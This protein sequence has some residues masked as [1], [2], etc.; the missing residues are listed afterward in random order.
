MRIRVD[1]RAAAIDEERAHTC[2][3]IIEHT[4]HILHASFEPEAPRRE[5]F[6]L[7]LHFDEPG[8]LSVKILLDR[9]VSARHFEMFLQHQ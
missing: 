8:L 6:V 3:H 2:S 5:H 4:S 1:R 9:F 7:T